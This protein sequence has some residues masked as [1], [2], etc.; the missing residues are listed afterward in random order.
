[1]ARAQGARAVLAA[2]WEASY[3]APPA[4]GF[5]SLPFAA[6]SLDSEQG[7]IPD[8]L[9]GL[10]RDP[11]DPSLDVVNANGDARVPID[12]RNFG[13][14]LR[15]IFG[16][17]TTTQ[18]AASGSLVFG[19][20]PAVGATVTINGTTF[21]FVAGSPNAGEI[22]IGATLADTLDNIEAELNGSADA[23]VDDATY[24]VSGGDTITVT[25]DAA[26]PAGN[27]FT[28]AASANSNA[29]A[30]AATL[31]GGAY[32][33]LFASGSWD[34]PSMAAEI[35]NPEVP[36][37]RLIAGIMANQISVQLQRSGLL[38]A[39]IGL[40][41]QGSDKATL[42]QAG[43]PTPVL[44]VERFAQ[45]NGAVLKDGAALGSVVSASFTY[46]NNLDLIE[47]IRDDGKID[48]ADPSVAALTG[49]AVV[50]FANNTLI[51]QAIAKEP[52][53]LAYTHTIN[54]GK[55]LVWTAHRVF[56]PKPKIPIDGP[57]GVQATFDWQAA[58]DS[59]PARMFTAELFNDVVSYA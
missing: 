23:D 43:S 59:A 36:N 27:A 17:P 5:F 51:D 35:G 31:T 14:W 55:K 6:W 12:L 38:S 28:L 8:D 30:S 45:F 16:A 57:R 10:G 34:L 19:G 32:K 37:Y 3:G 33:H 47:T 9:L 1:M 7:L 41:A 26:G 54:A 42:S 52:C 18:V 11:A 39:T 46:A 13:H 4:S 25:H 15:L 20:Q 48:S 29:L 44:A 21:V 50:R 56:L 22:E 53:E 49:Q 2:A 40:I 58:K 24:A